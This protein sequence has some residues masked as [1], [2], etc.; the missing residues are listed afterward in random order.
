MQIR[1]ANKKLEE[2]QIS[3]IL[4]EY[5]GLD[6]KN[7]LIKLNAKYPNSNINHATSKL[8]GLIEDQKNELEMFIENMKYD[9]EHE[10]LA[11]N[12]ELW[13]DAEEFCMAM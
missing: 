13:S 6:L 5:N 4:K 12:E 9:L 1:I 8:I 2:E 11:E 10:Q 7:I 3:A